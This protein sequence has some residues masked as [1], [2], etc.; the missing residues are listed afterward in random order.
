[1]QWSRRRIQSLMLHLYAFWRENKKRDDMRTSVLLGAPREADAKGGPEQEKLK[2][3]EDFQAKN[4][5]RN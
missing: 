2:A 4:C 3:K 5:L 1:M